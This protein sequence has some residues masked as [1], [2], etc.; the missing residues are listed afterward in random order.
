MSTRYHGDRPGLHGALCLLILLWAA[1][2][3]CAQGSPS[4]TPL[5]AVLV[6]AAPENAIAP[7]AT[8]SPAPS[9]TP[10]PAARLGA[11]QSAGQVNVRALPDVESE[12]LGTIAHGALYPALRQYYRW[13]EL[14]YESSPNGRAWVYGDLVSLEGDSS[15]IE[16]IDAF[17]AVT[18]GSSGGL[19]NQG[20]QPDANPRTIEIAT[21]AADSALAIEVVAET[22]L[23]TFTPP[24][25][26]APSRDQ[27]Q[28][29][30]EENTSP[31]R[32]PPLAP[33]AALGGLGL[34]GFLISLLRS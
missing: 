11:L 21:V 31:A 6:T 33:I 29:G 4:A 16:V 10:V 18:Q 28:R 1:T 5:L 14:A 32:L 34:L 3:L 12:L 17:D 7:A 8:S 9:P 2:P 24:A 25:T 15:A 19:A 13:Y 22:P 23:P 30:V 20:A 27:L 26:P